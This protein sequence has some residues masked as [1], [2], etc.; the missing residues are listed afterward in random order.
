MSTPDWINWRIRY[1]I[2]FFK[3]FCLSLGLVLLLQDL[4]IGVRPA[5]KGSYAYAIRYGIERLAGASYPIGHLD[6][7]DTSTDKIVRSTPIDAGYNSVT[8][9]N[10]DELILCNTS[11]QT[12]GVG[13]DI[14]NTTTRSFTN[15]LDI[16]GLCPMVAVPA[17]DKIFIVTIKNTLSQPGP[18]KSWTSFEI[19]DRSS[20]K[21]IKDIDLQRGE[22]IEDRVTLNK[23]KARLYFISWNSYYIPESNQGL[24]GYIDAK[25][26]KLTKQFDYVDCFGSGRWVTVKDNKLYITAVDATSK[27]DLKPKAERLLNNKLFVFNAE[28]LTLESTIPISILAEQCVYVPEVD[29][30]YVGH[31]SLSEETPQYI[32]VVDC[33]AEKVIAK[34]PVKGFRTMSYVGNHKLYVSSS[35]GLLPMFSKEEEPSGINVIDVRTNKV[36]NKIVG[37]YAPISIDY[38]IN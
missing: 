19:F 15:K 32:E 38:D 22:R 27:E 30:L 20:L 33:T 18:F 11:R 36:V 10:E 13:A 23:D 1:L 14:F 8:I 17:Q 3:I 31:S 34:I 29:C 37:A 4:C 28:T 5:E 9:L 21:K 2:R 7:I 24:I 6:Q 25:S 16:A 12:E 26:G 35:G